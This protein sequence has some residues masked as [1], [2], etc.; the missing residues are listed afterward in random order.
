MLD[1]LFGVPAAAAARCL[2]VGGR[3]VHLG[4]SAGDTCPLDSA[5][6]RSRSLSLLGYTNNAL[7]PEQRAGAVTTVA[8]HVARGELAVAHEVVPARRRRRRLAAPGRGRR[9]GRLVL[10][11]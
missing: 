1:P 3:L 8:A 4:G 5:T 2:G 7:S 10:V 9:R 11:P 6:L